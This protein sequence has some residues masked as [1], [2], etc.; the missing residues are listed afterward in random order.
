MNPEELQAFRDQLDELTAGGTE[1]QV[2]AYIDEQF[3]RLPEDMQNDIAASLLITSLQD[4]T[5]ESDALAAMQEE[6]L[7]AT[8][9]LE[10]VKKELER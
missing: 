7:A 3:P 2:R 6:S 8:E 4:E 9:G 5:Q 1:A 10:K